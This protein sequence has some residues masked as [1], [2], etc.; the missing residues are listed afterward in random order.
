MSK[1]K[2]TKQIE[3]ERSVD[4]ILANVFHQSEKDTIDSQ[5]CAELRKIQEGELFLA[6]RD[7]EGDPGF[8]TYDEFIVSLKNTLRERLRTEKSGEC[9]QTGYKRIN[10]AVVSNRVSVALKDTPHQPVKLRS[11]AQ[12]L[13]KCKRT[14]LQSTIW[15]EVSVSAA[16]KKITAQMVRVTARKHGI[17]IPEPT[18]P[19][20]SKMPMVRD[21]WKILRPGIAN[22]VKDEF[23]SA[24]K[25]I[26]GLLK[27]KRDEDESSVAPVGTTGKK[28]VEMDGLLALKRDNKPSAAEDIAPVT[29]PKQDDTPKPKEKLSKGKPQAQVPVSSK[30]IGGAAGDSSNQ[31]IPEIALDGHTV[32]VAFSSPKQ[33]GDYFRAGARLNELNM[34][35]QAGPTPRWRRVF[36]DELDAREFVSVVKKTLEEAHGRMTGKNGK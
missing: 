32:S 4:A 12:M 3:F 17:D 18:P 2:T 29:L 16:G 23:L 30:D 9:I 13:E 14:E 6:D 19:A 27:Q 35:D 28:P 22:I 5:L 7:D 34:E 8:E 26:D 15:A 1:D 24:M 20:S 21:A 33:C 10:E 36:N 31:A 25:T 11:Q